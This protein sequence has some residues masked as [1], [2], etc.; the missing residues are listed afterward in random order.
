MNEQPNNCKA[1]EY[2]QT[3]RNG[4][5]KVQTL[6]AQTAKEN[7]SNNDNNAKDNLTYKS[8][9]SFMARFIEV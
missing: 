1:N 7:L 3:Q 8:S 6:A 9:K 5:S 2:A 4:W